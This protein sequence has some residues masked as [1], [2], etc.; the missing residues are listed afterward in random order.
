MHDFHGRLRIRE[1]RVFNI[2]IE[3]CPACGAKLRVM[4]C[5]EA[6]KVIDKILTHLGPSAHTEPAQR[7]GGAPATASRTG[8]L[9]LALDEYRQGVPASVSA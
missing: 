6:P 8:A 5:I 3:T 9:S 2:D 4:A 7:P 1:P